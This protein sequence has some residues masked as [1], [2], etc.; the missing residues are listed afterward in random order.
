MELN[1]VN[2]PKCLLSTVSGFWHIL[3]SCNKIKDEVPSIKVQ[4]S[5]MYLPKWT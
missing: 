1:F 4:S 2:V 5:F 3:Y